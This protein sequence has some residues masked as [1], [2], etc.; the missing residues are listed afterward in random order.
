MN[1]AQPTPRQET[2]ARAS[3]SEREPR[4]P[5]G[6]SLTGFRSPY[7]RESRQQWR[8]AATYRSSGLPAVLP[9]PPR[10]RCRPPALARV[11]GAATLTQHTGSVK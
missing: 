7:V 6:L 8:V 11:G 4:R 3:P 2:E 5:T 9:P 10:P 1:A